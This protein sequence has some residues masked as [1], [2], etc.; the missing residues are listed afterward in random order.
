MRLTTFRPRRRRGW[1][2]VHGEGQTV[3]GHRDAID[4]RRRQDSEEQVVK[5]STATQ[6]EEQE[7]D[8]LRHEPASSTGR[9]VVT[10]EAEHA[11]MSRSV[12]CTVEERASLA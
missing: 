7:E 3:D 10:C 4:G 11:T 9:V 6:D 12:T 8:P 1:Q 5:E 2:P